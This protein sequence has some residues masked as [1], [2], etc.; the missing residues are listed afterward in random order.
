MG[1]CQIFG[2]V[3]G[4]SCPGACHC[5]YAGAG[6]ECWCEPWSDPGVGPQ[7]PKGMN[8][9][10]PEIMIEAYVCNQ[11]PLSSLGYFFDNLF[12]GQILIPASKFET[13]VTTKVENI[14][15]GDLIEELGLVVV[16]KPLVGRDLGK[17]RARDFANEMND[18][19]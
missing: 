17:D 7:V 11:M 13:Q 5:M 1:E 8:K 10:D 19:L 16:K 14:K 18:K 15:L 9:S 4:I 12:P 6:C 3:C 2:E